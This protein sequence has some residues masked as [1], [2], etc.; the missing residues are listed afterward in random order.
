MEEEARKARLRVETSSTNWD[1][2]EEAG[3]GAEDMP[4]TEKGVPEKGDVLINNTST[5]EVKSTL[6]QGPT[7]HVLQSTASS[8]MAPPHARDPRGRKGTPHPKPRKVIKSASI[9]VQ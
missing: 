9:R 4:L 2:D 5:C 6:G 7:T 3:I 8:S 1:D